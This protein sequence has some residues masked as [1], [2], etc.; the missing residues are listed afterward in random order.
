[1]AERILRLE[2]LEAQV[3]RELRPIQFE[4]Y[5]EKEGNG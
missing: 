5:K 4:I 1:L 2:V 3:E